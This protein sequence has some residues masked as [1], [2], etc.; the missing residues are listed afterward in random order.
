MLQRGLLDPFHDGGHEFRAVVREAAPDPEL[1]DR[2]PRVLADQEPPAFRH[3]QVL[4]HHAEDL[5]GARMA[6]ALIG[7][8]QSRLDIR[9]QDLQRPDV[10]LFGGLSHQLRINRHH[11]SHPD[12][13][14]GE[15]ALS[16][17]TISLI[18]TWGWM[19]V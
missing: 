6:L 5:A 7:A 15:R 17:P 8:G 3:L 1:V 12:L 11:A 10:Q 9:R 19:L 14:P 16:Q 2:G 13:L 18:C 4:E